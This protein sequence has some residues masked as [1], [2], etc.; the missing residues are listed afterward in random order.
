MHVGFTVPYVIG[1]PLDLAV[2]GPKAEE[3]GFES[4]WWAEHPVRPASIKVWPGSVSFTEEVREHFKWSGSPDGLNPEF[5]GWMVD[6]FVALA[7]ASAVTTTLKLGTAITVIPDRNPLLLAKEIA[8][9]DY[10]SGGRFLFGIGMGNTPEELEVMGGDYAH[11]W[12]QTREGVLA[13]KELWTEELAEFHGKYYDFPPVYCFPKPAQKPHPPI[14]LGGAAKNV[15]KRIVE[16]GDGWIPGNVTPDEVRQGRATLDELATAKGRDPKSLTI[17]IQYRTMNSLGPSRLYIPDK[18]EEVQEL[19]D[20][21]ADR[22]MAGL[23]G[24]STEDALNQMELLA[25]NLL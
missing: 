15:F 19:F 17:S 2:L 21:G 7:R 12:T 18:K 10:Y 8:T 4:I 22:V 3:L 20:A 13:L 14:L 24:T 1:A 23:S 6:P 25:R 5:L 9:L 16:Y 11:G